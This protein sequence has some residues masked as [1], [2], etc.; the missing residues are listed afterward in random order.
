MP[1]DPETP[2]PELTLRQRW[3]EYKRMRKVRKQRRKEK[4]RRRKD[5]KKDSKR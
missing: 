3:A 5:D 1:D 2:E 4:K